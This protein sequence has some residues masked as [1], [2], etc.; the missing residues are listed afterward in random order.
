M[1]ALYRRDASPRASLAALYLL[2]H[3]LPPRA[4]AVLA[5]MEAEALTHPDVYIYKYL[6]HFG[7]TTCGAE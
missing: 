7:Q 2:G 3:R 4:R 6:S 5:G 1:C